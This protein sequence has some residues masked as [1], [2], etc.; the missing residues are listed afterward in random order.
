MQKSSE[1][2]HLRFDFNYRSCIFLHKI[3]VIS[4]L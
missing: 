4:N 2:V 1:L 3:N